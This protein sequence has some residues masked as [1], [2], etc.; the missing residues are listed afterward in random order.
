MLATAASDSTMYPIKA[1]TLVARLEG[2]YLFRRNFDFLPAAHFAV[3]SYVAVLID[4]TAASRD[5]IRYRDVES[6]N[7]QPVAL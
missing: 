2:A 3:S 6:C 1:A 4:C 7:E 5:P